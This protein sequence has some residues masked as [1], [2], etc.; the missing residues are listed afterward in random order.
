MLAMFLLPGR[1]QPSVD[2]STPLWG[3]WP[4]MGRKCFAGRA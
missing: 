4:T 2:W 3:Q 1:S